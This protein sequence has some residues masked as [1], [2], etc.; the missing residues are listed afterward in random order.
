MAEDKLLD[1]AEAAAF[2]HVSETSLRRW[3]NEG[4]LSCL[5]VGRRRERR[6]R[7][8]DLIAFMEGPAIQGAAAPAAAQGA[9]PV[10]HERRHLC[11][12]YTTEL[13]RVRMAVNFLAPGLGT[14]STCVLFAPARLRRPIEARLAEMHPG[15]DGLVRDG[16]FVSQEYP[17]SLAE[18]LDRAD[19]LCRAAL[20]RGDT[21]IHGVGDG[22]ALLRRIG[23]AAMATYE[24][25]F[26]RLITR[27]YPI[28]ALCQ[29]DARKLSGMEVLRALE[30][31]PDTAPGVA[32]AY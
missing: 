10:A 5:R 7:R 1:I 2:L 18:R 16:R 27:Q 4:R 11:G 28:E 8:Q 9:A 20:Q 32:V 30:S 15:F 26:D 23:P 21:A 14:T 25:K 13:G 3:T 17:Q 6:F 22:T 31:H 12:F 24:A 19:M 29:F